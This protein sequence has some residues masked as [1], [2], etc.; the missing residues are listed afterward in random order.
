MT[1]FGVDLS[2]HLA[3]TGSQVP[4]LLAKCINEIDTRGIQIKVYYLFSFF[5]GG[6]VEEL[7]KVCQRQTS[8]ASLFVFDLIRMLFFLLL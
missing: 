7:I 8:W 1:T 3:E 6:G 2:Q 5:G 4:H